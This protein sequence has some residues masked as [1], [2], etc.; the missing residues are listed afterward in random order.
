MG[1]EDH[2]EREKFRKKLDDLWFCILGNGHP[3]KGLKW[4]VEQNANRIAEIH[5]FMQVVKGVFWKVVGTAVLGALSAL[6]LLIW[7]V[8]ALLVNHQLL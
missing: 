4:K 2:Q 1:M 7:K 8:V 5:G 3:E 6:C